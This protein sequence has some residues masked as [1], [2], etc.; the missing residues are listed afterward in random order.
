MFSSVFVIHKN[1]FAIKYPPFV[2]TDYYY[3]IIIPHKYKNRNPFVP[4]LRFMFGG[5]ERI[6]FSREL[7][8]RSST[9][10]DVHRKSALHRFPFKSFLTQSKNGRAIKLCRFAWRRRKDLNLTPFELQSRRLW[11]YVLCCAWRN[12]RGATFAASL[13]S[14]LADSALLGYLRLRRSGSNPLR[15]KNT[16]RSNEHAVFLA[17]KKGFEPS[18]RL[19]DLHP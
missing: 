10:A 7:R 19:P 4:E 16:A 1:C 9:V 14:E 12:A 5:E 11:H 2:V 18:R 6:W 13:T 8:A 17:E 3:V 15:Q